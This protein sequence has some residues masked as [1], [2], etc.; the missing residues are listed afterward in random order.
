MSALPTDRAF[1]EIDDAARGWVRSFPIDEVKR[2]IADLER[3]R[4]AISAEIEDLW[5][6]VTLWSALRSLAV[7]E[8]TDDAST[9]MPAPAKRDALLTLLAEAQG[10]PVR[11]VEMREEMIARGWL[12]RTP[13][14]IHAL[15]V[16]ATTLARRGEAER[17]KKGIYRLPARLRLLDTV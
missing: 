10:Q 2:H 9:D 8:V 4:A 5:R 1:H 15:E 12:P 3:E 14:A 6:R 13:K 16:A 7:S 17:V 11:L